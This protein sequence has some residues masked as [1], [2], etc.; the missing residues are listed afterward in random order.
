LRADPCD[1]TDTEAATGDLLRG[2]AVLSHLVAGLLALARARAGAA[3]PAAAGDRR[4]RGRAG[5]VARG[6]W[7]PRHAGACETFAL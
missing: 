7:A 5:R 3:A 6:S 2:P 4:R 1:A